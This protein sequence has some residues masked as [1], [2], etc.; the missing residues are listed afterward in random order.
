MLSSLL[1][2]PVSWDCNL[3]CTYCFYL[4]TEQ[5]YPGRRHLMDDT[6]LERMIRDYQRLAGEV[7]NYG[8]QGGEPLLAGREFFHRV[9]VLQEKHRQDGQFI[10]NSV[11]TNGVL[12]DEAWVRL[13]ARNRC[14]VGISLDG[15]E[16]VHDHYR[17]KGTH[18]R[19][20]KA[21]RL[22]QQAGVE[23]NVLTVIND[24]NVRLMADLYRYLRGLGVRWMQFIPILEPDE[25]GDA[26][27]FSV[28]AAAYGEFMLAVFEEWKKHDAGRISVRMFD[29]LILHAAGRKGLLCLHDGSCDAYVVVEH[30]GDVYPCDFFVRPEWRAGNLNEFP[31]EENAF[32]RLL[33][34]PAI[35][36]FREGRPLDECAGCEYVS[37]CAGG[38]QKDRLARQHG[39]GGSL[40][41]R[42]PFCIA[43]RMMYPKMLPYFRRLARRLEAQQ[44]G[45]VA[46]QD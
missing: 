28:D 1:V 2:K 12:V 5:I 32:E 11:Q 40:S 23:F 26:A 20:I 31:S 30:N 39:L 4:R 27:P 37:I 18:R 22:M 13:F 6:T 46:A 41:S 44:A 10:A 33:E 38:C 15:P 25:K 34:R 36:R 9:F 8:W 43:Y 29:S 24:R 7:A 21:I 14:L 16:S 42:S 19:V 3:R 45:G 35:K 17:G